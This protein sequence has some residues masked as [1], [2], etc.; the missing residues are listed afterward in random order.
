MTSYVGRRLQLVPPPKRP[1]VIGSGD[2]WSGVESQIRGNAA[3]V[4]CAPVP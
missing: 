3:V 4:S 2:A 1:E